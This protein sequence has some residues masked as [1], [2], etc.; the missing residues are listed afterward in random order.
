MENL[1][2]NK[3]AGLKD[4]YKITSIAGGYI[5]ERYIINE[6]KDMVKLTELQAELTLDFGTP[7]RDYFYA[8]ENARIYGSFTIPV[9]YDRENLNN[10]KNKKFVFQ[11]DTFWADPKVVGRRILASPYQPFPAILLS[12]YDT[13]KGVIIGSLSQEV[14]YHNFELEHRGGKLLV[15]IFS[16]LKDIAY[17]ELQ[18]SEELVDIFY[19]GETDKASDINHIFDGYTEVLRNYLKDNQGAKENNRHTMIWDSWNDGIYRDVNEEMLVEEAKAIRQYFPNV[20]WFQLD[21]GYSAYCE[22]DVDLDA[23]GLGVAYEGDKGIDKVK[24]PNGLKGYTD[25]IKAIGLKPAIWIGGF[26]PIKTKIYKEK[27]DWFIDYTYRVDFTQPLD[28][29][30]PEVRDY[31]T[32]ALDKLVTESGFEGVKH[33]FWSYAFEDK[34]DLLDRK[35]KS[36]Y[37]W[38]EWWHK[39][40]RK[41][42][43]DG[44]LETGCDVSMGN[45]FIG[46]YFNN[47]RFGLD[48]GAGDWRRVT[49]TMFWA[50]SILSNHTGDLFIPNS[51]SIGLLP[52]LNDTDFTFVVNFQIITRTLVEISGRFSKKDLSK[53]RLAVLQ[54]AT[55]YLNNGENVFFANFDY[56]KTGMN[57]P[58]IIYIKSIFDQENSPENV[59]TVAIFNAG[60]EPKEVKFN[61]ADIGLAD[62][63]YIIQNVWSGEK[64]KSKGIKVILQPHESRLYIIAQ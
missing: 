52:G 16:S 36:G 57:L 32:Y 30:K 45:P 17:R 54:R 7:E 2:I 58:N 5:V 53:S 4:E 34:H 51:D 48:I 56:R 12:N 43:G 44:Y 13:E 29:S 38:R 59:R 41:R 11:A 28:V 22:K 63:K 10:P 42:V 37:E 9:D 40:L 6:G 18:P 15:K 27:K 60:E 25:K 1:K 55:K 46:K 49:T 20:E 35:E 47:Y 64:V 3:K 24:F 62:E 39:E 19:I 23:H 8:N 21:D 26:C 61:V 33:D 50:V 31:M 14:F